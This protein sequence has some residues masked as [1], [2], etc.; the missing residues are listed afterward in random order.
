MKKNSLALCAGLV[1]AAAGGI[2][3]AEPAP[4]PPPAELLVDAAPRYPAA[5]PPQQQYI[6]QQ[7]YAAPQQPA[8]YVAPLAQANPYNNYGQPRPEVP[9]Y[10]PYN[11]MP[12]LPPLPGQEAAAQ[13][14]QP[15]AYS[16]AAYPP[17]YPT[18][19]PAPYPPQAPQGFPISGPAATMPAEYYAL[20]FADEEYIPGV[21]L[22]D[23]D[24]EFVD[25]GAPEYTGKRYLEP[26]M[27]QR[28]LEPFFDFAKGYE[29]R[30]LDFRAR[31]DMFT[32]RDSLAKAVAG[33]QEIIAMA[34]ASN[35]A[36][37]EAWYGV[38][39]CEYRLENYWRAFDALERSFP[40]KYERAEVEG[41]IRLEMFIGE[42]LWR[43][44]SAPVPDSRRNDALLTGY[45]AANRVYTA[46]LFNQPNSVDAPLAMLR[47]GDAMAMEENWDEAAKFY[48]S[49]I[50][51]YP[52]SEPAMQ[53]RSSLAEA[54]Y[55]QEWP[56]GFP[57]AARSDLA[58]V[59]SDVERNDDLLSGPAE[60]RRRRA[61]AL[62]N[63]NEAENLLRTAKSYM[64]QIRL[65]KSRDAA[66][67]Q[68]GEIVSRYPSTAQAEE[69][70]GLLREM[71]LE[72]PMVLSSGERFPIA[73]HWEPDRLPT[74]AEAVLG[75]N[76]GGTP[77]PARQV[78]ESPQTFSPM[79]APDPVEPYLK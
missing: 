18:P 7:Q 2:Q 58:R 26:G 11:T 65:Q 8:P 67:F 23:L 77:P 60:E 73:P 55:R 12:A 6:P 32:Y 49:V 57:E 64:R 27:N 21:V 19:Y 50:E 36:R 59:M 61:V 74:R 48:R 66:V 1:V 35:E 5:A 41:R 31:N 46:A 42:R 76:S 13:P 17:A 75:G 63:S 52:E 22:P 45:Q 43:M 20:P 69:A 71:G 29:K 70:A 40:E 16:P 47:R 4:L 37:E 34:D 54:V 25:P 33:Y 10:D 53:A 51:Y 24:P 14:P 3:A 15:Q 39:R 79:R 38:A 56:T 68:L 62:A 9:E 44:G 28:Q 30:A 78:R 72:P